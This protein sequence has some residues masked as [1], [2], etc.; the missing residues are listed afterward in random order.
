MNQS[1]KNSGQ[2]QTKEERNSSGSQTD[3]G[4]VLK[5][6]ESNAEMDTA[7]SKGQTTEGRIVSIDGDN[8]FV[9]IGLKVE[10]RVPLSEFLD[11]PEEGTVISV[12]IKQ[13]EGSDSGYLL[14]K[15]EADTIKSWGD[16]RESYKNEHQVQGRIISEVKGKGFMVDVE[17]V[18][19]FL[20]ISQLVYKFKNLDELKSKVLDFKIIEL[21]EKS[22]SGVV[23]RKKLLE[24][25]N[26]E[27]WDALVAHTHIGDKVISTV[28][29]V[30][31]FG[32]FCDV[33]GVIGLLR[34]NDISYKKF[35]PFKHIFKA[36]QQVE[37]KVLE[38]DP[39]NNRL[40][41]G[42][43]QLYEDPWEWAGRE[44]EK[45][46]VIRGL[47]TSLTGFGA[48]VELKEGLEGLI[49]TTELSWSKKPPAPKDVLKKGSEV[50]AMILDID[51]SKKRL[52]LGL[53][54]L[55][56]NP[57][58]NLSHEIRVGNTREGKITGLTK[59]G[60]FV[61]VDEAIE[62]LIHISDITWDEKIKNP[63]SFL[64]KGQ[65]VKY[66]ILDINTHDNKISC[67][68][69]QL[70]EHP[71]E[72]LRKKYPAGTAV[73]G[74]IKSVTSFGV[75]VEVEEGFEG[76]VH[77]SEIPKQKVENLA[78][79]FKVGDI[80]KTVILKIDVPTKKISLSVKDYE[81]SMEKA[82]MAKYMKSDNH[83]STSTIGDLIN[84]SQNK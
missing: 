29:K 79:S 58:E 73:E 6:W 17:G 65:V 84:I 63:I 83:P 1:S 4:Q 67:G 15:R 35:A 61:E 49:H 39:E 47:V 81:R 40:S 27:K 21:N 44:L 22:K 78:E 46:M 19:F 5:E 75:F 13:R 24:E 32:V 72:K 69:K 42:L 60:A 20:P 66:K 51:F 23:S 70:E 45:G 50:E 76:L 59:Y 33:E 56:P 26:K 80:V 14:S 64:K 7:L 52:S 71:Y 77:V 74:K 9:D 37:L 30:A 16:L 34:Q 68:L 28:S 43:K 55:T 10:G 2:N 18:H 41:L 54:Q 31:S 57:W 11:P 48:F 12:V 82:E 62:G 53:K 8:V 3:F 38:M 36:G 25:F